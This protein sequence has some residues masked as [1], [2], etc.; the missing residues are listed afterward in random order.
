MIMYSWRSMYALFLFLED[1]CLL[2]NYSGPSFIVEGFQNVNPQKRP[3]QFSLCKYMLRLIMSPCTLNKPFPLTVITSFFTF[4]HSLY[5][6]NPTII[7]TR[8][9]VTLHSADAAGESCQAAEFSP[10]RTASGVKP[11]HPMKYYS[12]LYKK[13]TKKIWTTILGGTTVFWNTAE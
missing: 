13:Q 2:V 4:S 8:R 1:T 11:P 9:S 3:F 10:G 7:T 12:T 5:T 6:E